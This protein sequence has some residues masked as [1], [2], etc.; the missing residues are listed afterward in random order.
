MVLTPARYDVAARDP[1]GRPVVTDDTAV[2]WREILALEREDLIALRN[3]VERHNSLEVASG[4]LSKALAGTA[5]RPTRL[6]G[7]LR[8]SA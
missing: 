6:L 7:R 3:L 5:G 8:G 1:F 2:L 4:A